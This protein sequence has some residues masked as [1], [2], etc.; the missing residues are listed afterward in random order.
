MDYDILM[1]LGALGLCIVIIVIRMFMWG[2]ITTIAKNDDVATG[3]DLILTSAAVAIYIV[4]KG[5]T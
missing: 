2:M 1:P 4:M 5:L 3:L